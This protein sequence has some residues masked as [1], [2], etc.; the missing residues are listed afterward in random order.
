MAE[1]E[2]LLDKF[3]AVFI[4]QFIAALILVAFLLAAFAVVSIFHPPPP[5]EPPHQTLR[6][7]LD[8]H[9]TPQTNATG[10]FVGCIFP[11]EIK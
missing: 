6:Q 9:G 10:D 1:F 2:D 5:T 3:M 7:C 8:A 11:T 4:P